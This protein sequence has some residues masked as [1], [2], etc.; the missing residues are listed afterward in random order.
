M[1][2]FFQTWEDGKTS[3]KWFHAYA[4]GKPVG[5]VASE[6]ALPMRGKHEPALTP[7]VDRG[8]FVIVINAE[9]VRFTGK[10][11][12]QKMYRRHTGFIGGLKETLASKMLAENPEKVI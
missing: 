3:A 11:A 10:E 2:T 4:A 1:K 7:C 5:R 9:K 6:V 12:D 8:D